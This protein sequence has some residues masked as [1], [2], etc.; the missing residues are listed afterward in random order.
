M[1]RGA[2]LL[3]LVAAGG[4]VEGLALALLTVLL[5]KSDIGGGT[6]SL[7]G[8]GAL[9]VPFGLGPALLAGQLAMLVLHLRAHRRWL[10][11]GIAAAG[12]GVVLVLGTF[13]PVLFLEKGA[14]PAQSRIIP[15]QQLFTV[16]SLLWIVA[17]PLVAMF[18]PKPGPTAR[19][20]WPY[21]ASM[22]ILPV[23]LIAGLFGGLAAMS[24]IWP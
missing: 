9:V 16:L 7:R 11:Y 1:T 19:P 5:S 3:V 20:R 13:I 23:A 15:V 12:F 24:A 18:L 4:A 2:R 14:V 21:L 17:A 8:N 22:G 10:A 6:L